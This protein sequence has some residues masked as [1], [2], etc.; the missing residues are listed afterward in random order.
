M[1]KSAF[2]KIAAIFI[3][4]VA[5]VIAAQDE[6]S[7]GNQIRTVLSVRWDEAAAKYQSIYAQELPQSAPFLVYGRDGTRAD[8][9][10]MG[11]RIASGSFLQLMVRSHVPVGTTS[12]LFQGFDIPMPQKNG[13]AFLGF[14]QSLPN[15]LPQNVWLLR[16][17]E[18]KAAPIDPDNLQ[19]ALKRRFAKRTM[20]ELPDA[21]QIALV[22]ETPPA[23]G[24]QRLITAKERAI[25]PDMALLGFAHHYAEVLQ[26]KLPVGWY[27]VFVQATMT[28]D[29][30]YVDASAAL[31]I[32]IGK[33]NAVSA[34][35]KTGVFAFKGD[36]TALADGAGELN[37]DFSITIPEYVGSV[38]ISVKALRVTH[39]PASAG[40]GSTRKDESSGKQN[41]YFF[42]LHVAP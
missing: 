8:W 33:P 18:G 10:V 28:A 20:G 22:E 41:H 11:E 27:A 29:H 16:N 31:L 26:E 15:G 30:F 40:G 25:S 3:S 7:Q 12:V 32:E 19:N 24:S 38:T 6:A 4:A 14:G 1:K 5:T 2:F 42:V 37:G 34:A 13:V 9:E 17:G 21:Q 39:S 35:L 23:S 36:L